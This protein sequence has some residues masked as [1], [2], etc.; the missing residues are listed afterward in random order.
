MDEANL[1]A[2]LNPPQLA[3]VSAPPGPLL[4]LAGPGSGKTHVITRRAAWLV[5]TQDVAPQQVL[6]VTFTNRAAQEMQGRLEAWLG[7]AARDIWVYTFHA[8]CTRL[9]RRNAAAAG[10]DPYFVVADEGTQLELLAEVARS[11]G[12]E[13]GSLSAAA[14]ARFHQPAQAQ[15]EQPGPD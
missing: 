13:P 2:D 3:A 15:P 7:P 10:L 12:S 4:V 6:C 14:R 5:A 1:L 11:A 8:L 9:L